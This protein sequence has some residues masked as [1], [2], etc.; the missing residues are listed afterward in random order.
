MLIFR[1]PCSFFHEESPKPLVLK[2]ARVPSTNGHNTA[3][4]VQLSHNRAAPLELFAVRQIRA[5]AQAQQANQN[6]LLG[7]FVRQEGLPPVVSRVVPPHEF[8][9]VDVNF[10][11]VS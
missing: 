4:H 3:V 5:L 8:N 11:V 1:Y 9:L 2:L 10:V 7:V 6:V